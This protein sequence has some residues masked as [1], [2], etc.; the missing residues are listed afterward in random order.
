MSRTNYYRVFAL[1]SIDIILTF[2]I[3]I[4]IIALFLANV[5]ADTGHLPF[6]RGWTAVHTNWDPVSLSY[7]EVLGEGISSVAHFY[8]VQW[9]S[10][11]LAFAIFGLFGVT[12]VARAS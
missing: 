5:V 11:I 12:K 6:Y 7:E 1:A 2:P 10:P 8:F 4:A 9:R 3:G